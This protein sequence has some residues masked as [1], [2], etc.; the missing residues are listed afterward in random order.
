M[1]A[2]F[3]KNLSEKVAYFWRAQILKAYF[4]KV[5]IEMTVWDKF[6]ACLLHHKLVEMKQNELN[7]TAKAINSVEESKI[8]PDTCTDRHARTDMYLWLTSAWNKQIRLPYSLQW[9]L[10]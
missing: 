5:H 6:H 3:P 8:L 7:I 2:K 9:E 10:F 4:V 1:A